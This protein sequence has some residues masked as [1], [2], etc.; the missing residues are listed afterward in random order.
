M[1]LRKPD[2]ITCYSDETHFPITENTGFVNVS[3]DINNDKLFVKLTSDNIPVKYLRLRWNFS[4]DEKY[5]A[6]TKIL[7]DEWERGYGSMSWNSVNPEKCMPWYFFASDKSDLWC[8]CEQTT[9]C[10]GVMVRPSA[11][12][13]WQT[14]TSGI[15]L[16]TDVR[17][18][19]NGV[20]LNGRELNVC[21]VLF[22]EYRGISAFEACEKFC[23]QMCPDPIL[24]K[25]PVYG[26]N[27]WYYAYGNS[28]HTEIYNDTKLVAE[29]TKG[30]SNRPF[31]VIDD[32]WQKYNCDGPWHI[33][34]EKFPDMKKLADEIKSFDVKPG[35]WVRY[36]ADSRYEFCDK[37]SDMRL[38]RDTTYL[39][40]SHPDVIAHIKEDTKRIAEWGYQL[41]KHDYSTFDLFG[42]WGMNFRSILGK[43][44][45]WSFY[46][47]NK[48]SAEI[49]IEFYTA[50][51][52]A[53]GENC[54][55]LGCNC[56]GHLCAGLA[57][58]NR[59]G[60]DTSGH[61]WERTRKMGVNTLAFRMPQNNTFYAADADCVGITKNVPWEKNRLWLKA[62]AN[63]G[64]PLF[65]SCT[66]NILDE[67][68]LAELREAFRIASYQKDRFIPLDWTE[69][70]CPEKW[71]LNGEEITFEW[72]TENG[73][74]SLR[75][76]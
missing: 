53:A 10:F 19:G 63:S 50:I 64:S 12:C 1:K 52:E 72:Y 35:I 62:L 59:T 27:N 8:P 42:D 43:A 33:G 40:P 15:T 71:S 58:L 67:S 38:S 45:G 60:D 57:H 13:F 32:G 24:P 48:T 16:W 23:S 66:P 3:F 56:I 30:L 2:L 65:V 75:L 44:N 11:M 54:L 61:E 22:R 70:S 28:S 69:T 46:N 25:E 47:K 73:C 36:L 74:E 17:N 49:V 51:L 21:T 34:N 39:D 4:D 41:I 68:Q 31:M 18:G 5:T 9:K 37:D 20:V 76:K 7:G 6:G 55:I 14:D 29:Y 26:S